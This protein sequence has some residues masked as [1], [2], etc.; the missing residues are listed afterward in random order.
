MG[1]AG[2]A[3][4]PPCVEEEVAPDEPDGTR[5]VDLPRDALERGDGLPST[6]SSDSIANPVS[7]LRTSRWNAKA[8]P[9][10]TR[11]E[12]RSAR[13]PRD[14]AVGVRGGLVEESP[15]AGTSGE[16]ERG[17]R[18][19]CLPLLEPVTVIWE[20]V[21]PVITAQQADGSFLKDRPAIAACAQEKPSPGTRV[22]RAQKARGARS[23]AR[24]TRTPTVDYDLQ[25]AMPVAASTWWV[26]PS[27]KQLWIMTGDPL[28]ITRVPYD[29]FR[30]RKD[31]D[32]AP[33]DPNRPWEA[34]Q[35]MS[36]DPNTWLWDVNNVSRGEVAKA[37]P[38]LDGGRWTYADS[39]LE[40]VAPTFGT[41]YSLAQRCLATYLPDSFDL[42]PLAAHSDLTMPIWTNPGHAVAA[43]K[44][45]R[46]QSIAYLGA[47]ELGFRLAEMNQDT[48]TWTAEDRALVRSLVGWNPERRGASFDL[49]S[50]SPE[51][52]KGL[53]LLLGVNAPVA[54]IWRREYASLTELQDYAPR[55]GLWCKHLFTGQPIELK[56]E[57]SRSVSNEVDEGTRDRDSVR[58]LVRGGV[59][60]YD[61]RVSLERWMVA[62]LGKA[63]TA[64]LHVVMEEPVHPESGWAR[65]LSKA[66]ISMPDSST[67]RFVALGA[68]YGAMAVLDR[69]KV[70]ILSCWPFHFSFDESDLDD[71]KEAENS[72]DPELVARL[73]YRSIP[74]ELDGRSGTDCARYES[75]AQHVVRTDPRMYA[76]LFNGFVESRIAQY[77]VGEH[78]FRKLQF[79][80]SNAA[81]HYPGFATYDED[82]RVREK[83]DEAALHLL[84]GKVVDPT[85]G[86]EFWYHPTNEM[87]AAAGRANL[88]GWTD[89]DESWFLNHVQ[90]VSDRGAVPYS[91]KEWVHALRPGSSERPVRK[92]V[93]EQFERGLPAFWTYMD[94]I[95]IFVPYEKVGDL[96]Q[97][98]GEYEVDED[99]GM[100]ELEEWPNDEPALDAGG[101]M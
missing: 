81:L 49:E 59:M 38:D 39:I 3:A 51:A 87:W 73:S 14:D 28:T 53:D 101:A 12:K 97:V 29:G 44:Y 30:A 45:V 18:A 74:G 37:L 88:G 66:Y 26:S 55:G 83:V 90:V 10:R 92:S 57:L 1:A 48:I 62:T 99:E 46:R 7:S 50:L 6:S 42:L 2:G 79:G 78:L 96:A 85:N 32:V 5:V 56:A 25:N 34:L 69:V 84:L 20:E 86:R 93:A 60:S 19:R 36:G 72:P 82:G 64:D 11:D 68:R 67:V 70:A 40:D 89:E 22:P 75:M 63:W 76:V 91:R 21:E 35:P 77:Y 43:L 61:E 95:S 100:P 33:Y 94:D 58:R 17:V 15:R 41:L 27:V 80:L 47:I 98:G 65:T 52:R 9:D 23:L 13:S 16:A 71:F 54:Y 31:V 8:R 4:G 24:F